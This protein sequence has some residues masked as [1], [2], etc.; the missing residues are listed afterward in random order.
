MNQTEKIVAACC[1]LAAVLCFLP[2]FTL[3]FGGEMAHMGDMLGAASANAFDSTEG[4]LAFVSVL[5]A[6]GLLLAGR[7]GALP[8]SRKTVL[9]A[10]LLATGLAAL[11]MLIFLSRGGTMNMPGMFSGGRTVWFYVAL[12]AVG[13]AVYHA[14]VLWQTGVKAID[15]EAG[16]A[17]GA[18]G[19]TPGDAGG[20]A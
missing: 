14:F 17:G 20:G 13:T 7:S 4:V 10:P 9:L 1:G 18:G 19:A 16:G 12:I 3:S 6:L 5:A 8:W 2:W 15:A 11:F